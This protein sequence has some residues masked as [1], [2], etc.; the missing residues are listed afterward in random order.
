[1][2]RNDLIL[3][4]II[5]VVLGAATLGLR[6]YQLSTTKDQAMAVVTIDGQLY[7]KYPLSED[8]ELKI[9]QDNGEY[10]ILHI[11]DGYASVTEASCRDKICVNHSHIHYSGDTIV[12]L[13]NKVV[14]SIENGEEDDID[15]A[16]N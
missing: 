10:N 4:I 6:F 15:G 3:I 16:T 9:T 12:C 11:E 13:P 7:G 1:M 14:V 5:L 8:M 2:K